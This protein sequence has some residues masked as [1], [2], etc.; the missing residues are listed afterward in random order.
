VRSVD[1]NNEINSFWKNRT[2]F[3][4]KFAIVSLIVTACIA[5]TLLFLFTNYP[6]YQEVR[7]I[8]ILLTIFV[9]WLSYESLK[10]PRLFKLIR[11]NSEINERVPV[12][13]ALTAH[14]KPVKYYNSGL[15]DDEMQRISA[16]LETSMDVDKIYLDADLNIDRLAVALSCQKHNL[17]Q[18]LNENYHMSFNE[19]INQKRVAEARV[20]LS[21]P[22]FNHIKIASIA[23]DSGFN[24]LSSFNSVFKKIEGSTPSQF[25]LISQQNRSQTWRV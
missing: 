17:S 9:Y 13:P 7:W 21:D 8:F 22:N 24:S 25:R 12:I 3:L 11:G 19:F 23:Y 4:R 2:V 10:R 18:V 5:S 6:N 1:G 14:R 20:F 16:A 15:K